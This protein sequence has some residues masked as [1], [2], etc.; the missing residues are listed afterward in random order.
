M[1][2]HSPPRLQLYPYN[3][4]TYAYKS[5]RRLTCPYTLDQHGLWGTTMAME[6]YHDGL[7]HW[8][9]RVNCIGL[10]QDAPHRGPINK[11]GILLTVPEGYR[12]ARI[13]LDLHETPLLHARIPRKHTHRSWHPVYHLILQRGIFSLQCWPSGVGS[14]PSTNGHADR[15][16]KPVDGAVSPGFLLLEAW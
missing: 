9:A 5:E 4:Y 10:H 11:A 7:R 13:G 15:A 1:Y 14:L 2:Y 8:H 3:Y 12:L 16:S 6:R